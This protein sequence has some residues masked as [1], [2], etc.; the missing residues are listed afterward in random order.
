[1][2]EGAGRGSG[3]LALALAA[4]GGA[5][6]LLA[7]SLPFLLVPSA[8]LG[9]IP[10]MAT[11]HHLARRAVQR[12]MLTTAGRPSAR[13]RPLLVDLGSGDGRI[14][15]A[16]AEA[17]FSAIGVE[18]NPVLLAASYL[19]AA[20]AGVLSRVSFRAADF[21][22][23]DL[24][25]VDVVTCFGVASC[26]RRLDAKLRREARP[27]TQVICFRFPIPEAVPE[28]REGELFFYRTPYP[29]A[30]AQARGQ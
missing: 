1:M 12:A 22:S 27:G 15:V 24:G 14:V 13:T 11:P 8:R 10:W 23:L 21:W 4:G 20:R 5:V 18:L 17:G 30:T 25:E 9:R 26:M 6:G 28:H 2:A 29:R 7:L 19:L 3:G 16:A